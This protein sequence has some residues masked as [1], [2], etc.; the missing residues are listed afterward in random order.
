METS[1]GWSVILRA[2]GRG[3]QARV[4]MGALIGRHQRAVVTMIRQ[5]GF[6][7]DQTAEDLK[8]GFFARMLEHNDVDRLDRERGHFRGWLKTAVHNFVCN[9]W[10][11]WY[12]KA[13]TRHEPIA[14]DV[15]AADGP[16]Y[17]PFDV[18]YAWDIYH[19]AF[20]ELRQ[21]QN[22]PVRFETLRR[23]LFGPELD[24]VAYDGVAQALGMSRV[25]VGVA[26]C[27]LRAQQQEIL[28]AMV[29]ETLDVD[30]STPEG[31][32]RLDEEVALICRIVS[33]TPEPNRA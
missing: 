11:R 8:Q 22:D 14:D 18:A 20:D 5:R 2:Q 13:G 7:P 30:Q 29:A 12:R 27:R 26:V 28:G 23:Y 9:D 32:Q 6:P 19:P 21:Q 33:D 25:G 3:P 17:D 10:E 16:V 15:L 4:A 24:V 31:R 1:S